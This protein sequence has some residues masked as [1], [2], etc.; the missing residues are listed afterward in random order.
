[1]IEYTKRG[2][3]VPGCLL[4]EKQRGGGYL[5]W[6][7]HTAMFFLDQKTLLKWVQW[8]KGTS[9]GDALRVWL[10]PPIED[11]QSTEIVNEVLS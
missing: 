5:A 7:P 6:R 11:K 4:V 2:F 9:T 8:P 10:E 1:M 3:H